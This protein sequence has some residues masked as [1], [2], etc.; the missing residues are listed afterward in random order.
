MKP[1]SMRNNAAKRFKGLIDAKVPP[2]R[3]DKRKQN[4]NE[5]YYSARVK[6]AREASSRFAETS[7]LFSADNK[8][9][10]RVS[11]CTPAVDRRCSVTRFFPTSD[12]PNMYDH[13]FPTPGYL[14]TPAG[15]MQMTSLCPPE[16]TVDKLGR[17][18]Y[19]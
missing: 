15:Y 2:K 18:C 7:V 6:Y 13:D 1:P 4:I 12:S 3:N 19:R 10:L 17:Q 9:K 5:H 14:I 16:L 8:N 11:S